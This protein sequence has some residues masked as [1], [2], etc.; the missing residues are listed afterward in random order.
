M[1]GKIALSVAQDLSVLG[2]TPFGSACKL[3]LAVETNRVTPQENADE[4]A[5]NN[6]FM[7]GV[8]LAF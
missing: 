2:L 6:R 3:L 5:K 1:C 4:A 8:A 7:G